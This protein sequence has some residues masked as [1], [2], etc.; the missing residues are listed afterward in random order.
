MCRPPIT[1]KVMPT[2]SLLS[3]VGGKKIEAPGINEVPAFKRLGLDKIDPQSIIQEAKQ[4]IHEIVDLL[5]S[6]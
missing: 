5:C 3:L 6:E 1:Q 2:F 4:E